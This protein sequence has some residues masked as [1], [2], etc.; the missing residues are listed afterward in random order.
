[1]CDLEVW[2]EAPGDLLRSHLE[3]LYELA[4]E[5]SEKKNNVWIMRDL[6]LVQRLLI[7][8][9]EIKHSA[10]RQILFSLLC[11]LL[12]GQPRQN[13]LLLFGQFI[14]SKLPNSSFPTEKDLELREADT[15]REGEGEDILLRNRCLGLLHS[16]IF[17]SRNHI[18]DE[19]ARTL[20]F[21]W[22]LLFMQPQL[23][24]TTVVWSLRILVAI[25]SSPLLLSR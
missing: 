21:D 9:P 3:H 17:S 15:E 10:T 25:C 12:S 13:D 8:T 7:I 14:A 16:L 2:H 18:G 5:S 24:S 11:V 22:V 1:M 19:I 23:H 6:N 4:A 20:G